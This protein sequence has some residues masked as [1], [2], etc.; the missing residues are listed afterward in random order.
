VL[1]VGRLPVLVAF[2]SIFLSV[3]PCVGNFVPSRVSFLLAMRYY[4]GNWAYNVWLFRQG[5]T[6]K[7]AKLTKAA[8]TMR[9]QLDKLLPDPNAVGMALALSLAHR[10][11][12]LEGRPLLEALPRAVD[13]IEDYEWI[14]GEVFAGM[15]PER[16]AAAPR[17]AGAVRLRAGRAAR[18]VDRVAAAVRPHDAVAD[19]GRGERRRRGGRDRDRADAR[20][21]AVADGALR[22]SAAARAD[23]GD[24]GG[25]HVSRS[26]GDRATARVTPSS[27]RVSRGASSSRGRGASRRRARSARAPAPR[28]RDRSP[29]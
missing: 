21:P 3:V 23:R 17:R 14:D 24:R 7:L 28:S 16:R 9:E 13:D 10:F 18:R 29:R 11:M 26:G 20:R 19:R 22:R 25:A 15:A 6:A 8:G 12:H 27:R 1:A 2:L 4:A 5:S